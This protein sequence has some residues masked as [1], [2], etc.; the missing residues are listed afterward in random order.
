MSFYVLGKKVMTFDNSNEVKAPFIHTHC[1]DV[2]VDSVW[3]TT[4]VKNELHNS[5]TARLCMQSTPRA[6]SP[7]DSPGTCRSP[8]QGW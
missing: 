6:S 8:G 1:L 4:A 7:Y 3:N 2:L 5:C